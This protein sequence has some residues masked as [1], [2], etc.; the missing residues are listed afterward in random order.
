MARQEGFEPPTY[1]LEGNCSIL[2]SYWRISAP[3]AQTPVFPNRN[4]AKRIRFGEGAA[5]KHGRG[6]SG[7]A[8]RALFSSREKRAPTLERVMGIEPTY[9]AWKAGVLPLNYTRRGA[10]STFS[11]EIIP[12]A[13]A[14]C[15]QFCV[16]FFPQ[17]RAGTRR[18]PENCKIG[19]NFTP[20]FRS[21]WWRK[22]PFSIDKG[23]CCRY[24]IKAK[25]HTLI[26]FC[27]CIQKNRRK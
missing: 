20:P 2:L 27:V 15:Q 11:H 7:R 17:G 3:P 9:P 13:R 1:C 24:N 23:I 8:V 26:H 4:P 6:K 12:Y 19:T 16:R 18:E 5:T 21:I 22:V 14:L 10:L 25:I